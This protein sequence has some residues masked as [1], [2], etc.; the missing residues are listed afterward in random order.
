MPA[1]AGE[2]PAVQQVAAR[3]RMDTQRCGQTEAQYALKATAILGGWYGEWTPEAWWTVERTD[4]LQSACLVWDY[5][6]PVKAVIATVA[7]SRRSV[8]AGTLL[9]AVLATLSALGHSEC[10]A[11]VPRGT[12]ASERLF[13]SRGFSPHADVHGSQDSV[14]ST[15]NSYARSAT[16]PESMTI[17]NPLFEPRCAQ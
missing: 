6:C 3:P 4:G 8:R 2:C 10:C 7:A 12:V 11:M 14:R 15:A 1:G 17:G 5:K 13:E 9:D 16:F